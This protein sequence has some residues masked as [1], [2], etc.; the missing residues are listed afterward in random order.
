LLHEFAVTITVAVLISGFVSLTLT[1][2]LCSR[3]LKPAGEQRHSRIYELSERFFEGMLRL[4]DVTLKWALRRRLTTLVLSFV[5]L[6][7]AAGLYAV[8]SKGFL[9]S[10]DTGQI[11]G[12]TEAA[13]GI[14][15]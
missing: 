5:F 13:Q 15:F 3:F 12:F 11:T 14:S 1:P 9:P 10:E 6:I 8:I 7:V 2:M 4:Y